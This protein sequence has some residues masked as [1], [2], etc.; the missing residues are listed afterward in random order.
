[1]AKLGWYIIVLAYFLWF[2]GILIFRGPIYELIW[3]FINRW[4]PWKWNL[5]PNSC[6]GGSKT[7]KSEFWFSGFPKKTSQGCQ[8]SEGALWIFLNFSFLWSV[9]YISKYPI[10]SFDGDR[11]WTCDMLSSYVRTFPLCQISP[12]VYMYSCSV[13]FLMITNLDDWLRMIY[14]LTQGQ[15]S[16]QHSMIQ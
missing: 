8:I 16:D 12:S 5:T 10:I 7:Y 2:L 15:L 13:V 6:S 9:G 11:S 1:M 4:Q 3:L 14:W